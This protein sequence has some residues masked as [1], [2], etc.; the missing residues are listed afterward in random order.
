ME[1][2][3]RLFKLGYWRGVSVD[4]RCLASPRKAG[5]VTPDAGRVGARRVR[6]RARG[7]EGRAS[8]SHGMLVT[9]WMMGWGHASCLLPCSGQVWRVE[10]AT[11]LALVRAGADQPALPDW[12]DLPGADQRWELR[13][14][15]DQVGVPA[16]AGEKKLPLYQIVRRHAAAWGNWHAA[17]APGVPCP[18]VFQRPLA[19]LGALA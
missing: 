2:R 7:L 16:R 12:R 4:S 8:V 5:S 18:G 1:P 14:W 3:R 17:V 11:G 6:R 19:S 10:P 15:H 9:E 13:Y